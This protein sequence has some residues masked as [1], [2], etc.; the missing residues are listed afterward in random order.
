MSSALAPIIDGLQAIFGTSTALPG[1]VP[2]LIVRDEAGWHPATD[3]GGPLL[4]VLLESAARR[5]AAKPAAAAALAWKAYTHWVCLP[6]VLGWLAARRV[7]ALTGANVLVRLDR[8]LGLLAVGLRAGTP[9]FVLP[10]DSAAGGTVVADEGQLLAVLRRSLLDEHLV[11]LLEILG[12][13]VRLGPRTLLGSVAATIAADV[14]RFPGT[15]PAGK[16]AQID[17]LLAALG[18]G[19]L[20]DLTFDGNGTCSVRRRTC[21]LAFTLPRPRLC[22]D[23]VLQ[24]AR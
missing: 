2:G 1:L 5:W 12:R 8:P 13:R 24:P 20:L 22:R 19:G 6:A 9:L 17:S 21:C 10:G 11:P 14:L 4:E 23:C 16:G 7:P 3:L 18:L 15:D